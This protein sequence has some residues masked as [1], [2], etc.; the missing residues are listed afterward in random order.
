MFTPPR[1]P[2]TSSSQAE[3]NNFNNCMVYA[4]D[5][6]TSTPITPHV[7]MSSKKLKHKVDIDEL[8]VDSLAEDR[9]KSKHD[10]EQ[11]H[12]ENN[13]SDILFCKSLIE[14]LKD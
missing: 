12:M 7:S 10:E 6:N 5:V 14:Q 9:K 4:H 3:A 2:L 1:S 13:D 8:L 11:K